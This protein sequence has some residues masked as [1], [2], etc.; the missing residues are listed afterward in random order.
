MEIDQQLHAV[1]CSASADLCGSFHVIVPAAVAVSAAVIRVVPDAHADV[2]DTGFCKDA[3]NIILFIISIVMEFH[4][5]LLD[6]NDRGNV[7]AADRLAAVD[8]GREM[9]KCDI[10]PDRPGGECCQ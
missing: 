6:G 7:H 5:R 10:M 9:R 3:E 8:I 1:L 4:A 2:V